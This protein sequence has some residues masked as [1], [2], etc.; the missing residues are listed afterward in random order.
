MTD[1][2]IPQRLERLESR[3]SGFALEFMKQLEGH[4][5]LLMLL[6]ELEKIDGQLYRIEIEQIF[7]KVTDGGHKPDPVS[8]SSRPSHP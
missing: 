3:C 8:D 5:K 1:D 6:T 4:P 2:S 7:L